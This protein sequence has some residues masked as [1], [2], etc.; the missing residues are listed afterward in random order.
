MAGKSVLWKTN[1]GD[2]GGPHVPG[3]I[4]EAGVVVD[5]VPAARGHVPGQGH[6]PEIDLV[7]QG[8]VLEN[9]GQDQE[10]SLVQ[11]QS[12]VLEVGARVAVRAGQRAKVN[13][14]QGQRV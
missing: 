14:G 4:A 3:Q 11:G 10:G 9:Q 5:L 1:P 8:Q 7:G 13:L 12:L 2:V 6:A